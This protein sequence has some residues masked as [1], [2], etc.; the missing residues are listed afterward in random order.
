MDYYHKSVLLDEVIEFL[1]VKNIRNGV[2][3]DCTF[4]GGGHSKA[5]LDLSS[6]NS[7]I[8]IDQD[9]DAINSGHENMCKYK[10]R[11]ILV[12]DNYS[13]FEEILENL[14]IKQVDGILI[15]SG[16]SSYQLDCPDRGFSYR[17]DAPLDMR[18]NQTVNL[19]AADVVNTY[20]EKMIA[21]IIYEYGEERFSRKIAKAIITNR[22]TKKIETTFELVNII[23]KNVYSCDKHPAKRTFQALRIFVNNELQVLRNTI[24]KMCEILR[25]NGRMAIITFHSLEDRIVKNAYKYLSGRSNCSENHITECHNKVAN[26]ITKKPIYPSK[27]E[28]FLNSR[29]KSAKLRVLQKV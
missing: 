10:D 20:S 8:G 24:E 3:L 14:K 7:V 21:D 9:V 5:I 27:R 25:I 13:N 17:Y 26:I 2:F 6:D 28:I 22:K 23:R 29:A 12:H 18:M 19:T 16:V 11:L 1:E 4:G 15:D